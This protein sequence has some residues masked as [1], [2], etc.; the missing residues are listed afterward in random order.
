LL[1]AAKKRIFLLVVTPN[2]RQRYAKHQ[3]G[4]YA[5]ATFRK[6]SDS[7]RAEVCVAGK[8]KSKSFPTKAEARSWAVIAEAALDSPEVDVASAAHT[9]GDIFLRYANEISEVKKGARW[10]IVRLKKF[11]RDPLSKIALSELKREHF[12]EWVGRQMKTLKASS[13]NRELNLIS[14]AL[15]QARRWRLMFDNPLKD[16][17]RPKDPPHRDRRINTGEIA[18]ILLSLNYTEESTVHQQQQRVAVAFL[19]AIET[20]MRAGEICSL[21]PEQ[22]NL[23]ER[24]AY[25]PE[26]KNGFPRTVPL[27]AEAVRL[28]ERLMPCEAGKTIFKV[29]SGTLST[30]FKRGV[31]RT[32]IEDLT[33]HDARHEATTRL[34]KRLH[35]LALARATGHK[36]IKQLQIYYNETAAELAKLLD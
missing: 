22:I 10:E 25:L 4:G 30:I 23:A 35:I 1:K 16:L 34:A 18:A 6:I 11:G 20:A 21:K 14:H 19:F 24:T 32:G 17:R 13:V 36:D 5:M 33:F 8:R 12:E 15:T 2:L 27:S 7:W 3:L 29:S 31:D 28:I 9:L 26:T